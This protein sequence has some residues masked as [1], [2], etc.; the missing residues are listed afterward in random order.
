MSRP[1]GSE[2]MIYHW[3]NAPDRRLCVVATA[4]WRP[5]VAALNHSFCVPCW[6]VRAAAPGRPPWA[7]C[8]A[9]AL[10][11]GPAA[12]PAGVPARSRPQSPRCVPAGRPPIPSATLPAPPMPGPGCR[13]AALHAGRSP[14]RYARP[15][16]G[17]LRSSPRCQRLLHAAKGHGA[18]LACLIPV[19][20][21]SLLLRAT[22]RRGPDGPGRSF[23]SQA[24]K[25]AD[26][27][28]DSP[29]IE[30]SQRYDP[31]HCHPGQ[32]RNAHRDTIRRLFAGLLLGADHVL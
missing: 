24:S 14:P 19:L 9:S 6:R 32:I 28:Y 31:A 11:P 2:V 15:C 27:G 1:A 21:H 10:R 20:A 29:P 23:E 12:G 26:G 13:R 25:P 3:R 7:G 5:W 16:A 17:P 22:P 4:R 30:T 8:P 18:T